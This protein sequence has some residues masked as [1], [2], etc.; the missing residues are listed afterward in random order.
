MRL[1]MLCSIVAVACAIPNSTALGAQRP[2][3]NPLDPTKPVRIDPSQIY[4][5]KPDL[6]ALSSGSTINGEGSALTSTRLYVS[7]TDSVGGTNGWA[8]IR[9]TPGDLVEG[10]AK[11]NTT[12]DKQADYNGSWFGGYFY[13]DYNGC[14]WI[15]Y[16]AV[17]PKDGTPAGLCGSPSRNRTDV[18]WAWNAYANCNTDGC[19][20][21]STSATCN[22]VPEYANVHPWSLPLT[23]GTLI[24][25]VWNPG[26]NWQVMW[27][28][29]TNDNN[30]VMVR[31]PHIDK[32]DGNWVFIPRS[33]I[34][35]FPN[36]QLMTDG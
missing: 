14:G 34:Q 16:S 8:R 35:S 3:T 13:G 36:A 2:A 28:Y 5:D 15:L 1:S 10:N 27:R 6:P 25:S 30:A 21:S 22:P 18:G 4:P 29:A 9:T 23:P 24:R 12:F 19:D 31:D 33:C 11:T 17:D 26:N 20:G 7:L 32:R